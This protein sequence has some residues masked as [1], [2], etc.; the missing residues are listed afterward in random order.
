MCSSNRYCTIS[1]T[2]LRIAEVEMV[3]LFKSLDVGAKP[4]TVNETMGCG[5]CDLG[6]KSSR[7]GLG[8]EIVCNF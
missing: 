7:R 1:F 2:C 5:I 4:H 6:F 3:G 8:V